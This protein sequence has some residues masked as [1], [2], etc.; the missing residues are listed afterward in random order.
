MFSLNSKNK[1]AKKVIQLAIATSSTKIK[2]VLIISGSLIVL[3]IIFRMILPRCVVNPVLITTVY[4][5]PALVSSIL[6][7]S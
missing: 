4:V 3:F 1:V 6:D 2:V 7:P 5:L